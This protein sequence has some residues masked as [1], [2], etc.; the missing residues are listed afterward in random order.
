[1][2]CEETG[3]GRRG[4]PQAEGQERNGSRD[5]VILVHGLWMTGREMSVLGRRE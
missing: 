2:E 5:A 3:T 1:M 4:L